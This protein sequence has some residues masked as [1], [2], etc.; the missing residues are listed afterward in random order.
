MLSLGQ[1]YVAYLSTFGVQEANG[2][3]SMPLAFDEQV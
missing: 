3:T 2:A 1:R